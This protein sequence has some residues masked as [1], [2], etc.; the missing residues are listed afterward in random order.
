MAAVGEPVRVV[1]LAAGRNLERR[2]ADL[3]L[4]AGV[5]LEVRQRQGG[6]LVVAER[7]LVSLWAPV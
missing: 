7:V 6:G 1:A 2:M 4:H 3:G 5:V